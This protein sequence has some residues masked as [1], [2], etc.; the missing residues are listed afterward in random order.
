V[1][2]CTT[3]LYGW[4]I[5]EFCRKVSGGKGHPI[6]L[7]EKRNEKKIGLDKVGGRYHA[8]HESS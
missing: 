5:I 1:S 6:H 4:G 7:D 2:E 3:G 8:K